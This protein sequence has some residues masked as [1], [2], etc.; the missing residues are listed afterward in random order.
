MRRTQPLSWILVPIL[1]MLSMAGI[2]G[3]AHYGPIGKPSMVEVECDAVRDL[4]I[5]EEVKGKAA[6]NQYRGFVNDY[7]ALPPNSP[8]RGGLVEAMAGSMIVVLGHDLTIYKELEKFPKCVLQSKRDQIA[9]MI[10][11]TESTIN[12]LNGSTPIEGNFF[13]PK[14]GSWNTAFYEDYISALD[15]LKSQG[16]SKPSS[17]DI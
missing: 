15:F 3:T 10:T 12:F 5:S 14:L 4:I 1:I 13:D 9:G 2:W 6:W 8:D 16:K 17:T 7:L 11:E